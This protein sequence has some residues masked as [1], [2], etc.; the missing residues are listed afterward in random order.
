VTCRGRG[1]LYEVTGVELRL[2]VR[3]TSWA[4]GERDIVTSERHD[5]PQRFDTLVE[6]LRLPVS[7]R[8]EH[9]YAE[10]RQVRLKPN[11]RGNLFAASEDELDDGAG[12]SVAHQLA[13]HGADR[14]GTREELLNDDSR[15]RARLGIRFGDHA[16]L[17]PVIAYVCT[18]VA[19]VANG[20]TA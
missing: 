15:A 3:D 6:R 8:G 1:R 20:V 16:D 12:V 4:N 9:L 11:G 14:T 19:P 13:R 5:S 17:V 18:R 7:R 2:T 10:P